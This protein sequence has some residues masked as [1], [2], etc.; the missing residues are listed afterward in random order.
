MSV[1]TRQI[2]ERA[3]DR[4]GARVRRVE[5]GE[6]VEAMWRAAGGSPRPDLCRRC[7][8]RIAALAEQVRCQRRRAGET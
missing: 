5:L 7:A 6:L 8:A 2:E 1:T 4:C 3:C